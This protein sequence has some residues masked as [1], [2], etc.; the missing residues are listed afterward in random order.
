MELI[1][2]AECLVEKIKKD[3]QN[4]VSLVHV[5]GSYFYKDTHDLSDLDL[6]FVPKSIRGYYLG[7]TFIINGIGYD[8]WALSWDRLERIANHEENNA[9]LITD[10]EILYY[11]SEEDLERFNKLKEKAGG[12]IDREKLVDRGKEIIKE[13]HREY[14]NIVNSGN[15][16]EVRKAVIAIINNVSFLLSQINST[17]IKRGRKHL[18]NEIMGMKIIPEDFAVIYEKFFKETDISV[19]RELLFTFICNV[20]TLLP[21][22]ISGTFYD[23][24]KGFYEEMV[25]S[26]NRIYHAC[27]TGDIYTPLYASVELTTEIEKLFERSNCS[28]TLPDL[29]GS[30]DPKNLG[31]MKEVAKNHQ[32]ELVKVLKENGIRIRTF[33]GIDELKKFLEDL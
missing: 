21:N 23:N 1:E 7:Q 19:I 33:N 25:Q 3:Y 18:K 30:Y 12:L 10:G 16:A 6:Y 26:Y 31:K 17:P 8:Y 29:I 13:I 22:K 24:F 28:F 4:D 20:E 11:N 5:H 32:E 15:I 2:V 14:F 27:D 9:S